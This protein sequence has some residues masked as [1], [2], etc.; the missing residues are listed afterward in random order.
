MQWFNS[1]SVEIVIIIFLILQHNAHKA[2][3]MEEFVLNQ[4]SVGAKQDG[5]DIIVQHV[6]KYLYGCMY[7]CMHVVHMHVCT[8]V[9]MYKLCMYV[10]KL[11][12]FNECT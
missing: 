6:C 9:Y 2:V 5:Q 11:C 4:T 7:V 12:K 1:K 8:Y 3:I 10:C